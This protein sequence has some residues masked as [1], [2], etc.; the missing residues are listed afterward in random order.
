[1]NSFFYLSKLKLPCHLLELLLLDP[2][3]LVLHHQLRLRRL[4]V[5]RQGVHLKCEDICE[6][7]CSE[8][9]VW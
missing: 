2:Q 5:L 1:M 7:E 8:L 3:L 9:I 4:E 6:G